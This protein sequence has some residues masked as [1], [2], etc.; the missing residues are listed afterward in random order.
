MS[1]SV[2]IKIE[3]Q[4]RVCV[5]VFLVNLALCVAQPTR[6]SPMLTTVSWASVTDVKSHYPNAAI[7]LT[8]SWVNEFVEMCDPFLIR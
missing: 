2:L 1:V 4:E 7:S 3:V 6:S 5:C 8:R